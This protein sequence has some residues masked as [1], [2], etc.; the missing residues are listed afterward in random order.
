MKS[1]NKNNHLNTKILIVEDAKAVRNLEVNMLK[2]LGFQ[3]I[4]EAS[5]GQKAIDILN[6]EKDVGLVISD[7]NMPDKTGYD[8]LVWI[9]ND[10]I[11]KKIPFIMATGQGEKK[12][13]V[14]AKKAGANNFV[15]KPF[16]PVEFKQVIESTLGIVKNDQSAILKRNY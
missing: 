5:D 12:K 6:I 14:K 8:L 13:V 3:T 4:L 15:T 7:W 10:S 2:D 16:S 11:C 1:D 9:R